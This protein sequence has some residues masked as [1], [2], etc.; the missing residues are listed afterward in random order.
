MTR[1]MLIERLKEFPP[2]REVYI[3]G[4]FIWCEAVRVGTIYTGYIQEDAHGF[5]VDKYYVKAYP[6]MIPIIV[7]SI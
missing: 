3:D 4:G 2:D 1:D 7:I 5:F 6:G